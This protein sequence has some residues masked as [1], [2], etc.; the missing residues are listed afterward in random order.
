MK[1]QPTLLKPS[2]PDNFLIKR[3][4]RVKSTNEIATARAIKGAKAGTV[5][6][7]H[8]Q[9]NGR[10][11]RGSYWESEPGNIYASIIL[12]PNCNPLLAS[13]ASFVASLAVWD[14]VKEQLPKQIPVFCKWPNDI[15]IM[16]KKVSGILLETHTTNFK[17]A[18]PIVDWLVVGVGI[19]LITY[20]K[21]SDQNRYEATSLLEV[22]G[23]I[24]DR[25]NTISN[26][27][28]MFYNHLYDWHHFGFPHIRNLWLKRTYN[29]GHPIT[30]ESG[31]SRKSGIF[32]GID[33]QGGLKLRD[34]EG[35]SQ[36]INAGD[37]TFINR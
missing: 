36:L 29:P 14:T 12:R 11:R 34:A 22:T 1:I 24:L 4:G 6:V 19:N 33:Q 9:S 30:F 10:G 32:L 23:N 28:K 7:A 26:F 31:T 21:L 37:V 5:I 25:D 13:Q 18:D 27:L 15:L 8:S 17:L 16:N 35:K 20:P 2:I 3:L